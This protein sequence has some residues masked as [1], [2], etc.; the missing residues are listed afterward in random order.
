MWT[1]YYLLIVLAGFGS[2]QLATQQSQIRNLQI[3]GNVY[4]NRFIAISL[5][6][7]SSLWFFGSENRNLSDT[8]GGLDGGD[9]AV[10]F[11]A[12]ALTALMA[13]LSISHTKRFVHVVRYKMKGLEAM[14]NEPYLWAVLNNLRI[15]RSRWKV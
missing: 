5:I 11:T 13:N 8:N 15:L 4:L 9:Q 2:L 6:I 1:D 3:T 14:H 7:G 10:L 12:G